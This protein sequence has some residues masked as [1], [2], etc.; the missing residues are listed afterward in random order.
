MGEAEE[1]RRV[2]KENGKEWEMLG[3]SRPGLRQGN[4][5]RSSRDWPSMGGIAVPTKEEDLRMLVFEQ[6]LC[7]G[8]G[9]EVA[10]DGDS[11]EDREQG[12]E[13]GSRTEKE[14]VTRGA[15]DRLDGRGVK[16]RG[17]PLGCVRWLR[18]PGR[19]PDS[20]P[21]SRRPSAAVVPRSQRPQRSRHRRGVPRRR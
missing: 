2:C 15:S 5:P 10:E 1:T 12:M 16:A 19:S 20:W 4:A 9:E 17:A 7:S 11:E 6:E 13:N 8:A 14:A 3:Q 18:H 21:R